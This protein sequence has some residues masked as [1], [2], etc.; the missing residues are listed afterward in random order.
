M[1]VLVLG[2]AM[3]PGAGTS[4]CRQ[5]SAHESDPPPLALFK[6]WALETARHASGSLRDCSGGPI[7]RDPC[8]QE[9]SE[10]ALPRGSCAGVRGLGISQP[11]IGCHSKVLPRQAVTRACCATHNLD[12]DC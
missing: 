8:V 3:A 12:L 4:G 6:Y 5:G 10:Q 7:G 2:I 11:L 1:A 9:P